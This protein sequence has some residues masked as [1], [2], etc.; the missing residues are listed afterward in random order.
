MTWPPSLLLHA[1]AHAWSLDAT[2]ANVTPEALAA[3]PWE[4]AFARIHGAEAGDHVNTTEDRPVGH[5]WLRDPSRAPSLALAQEIQAAQDEVV[6]LAEQLRTGAV[7]DVSGAA[8]TDVL[9]IGVGG[10]LLGPE[11]LVS[12]LGDDAHGRRR[13]LAVHAMDNIDPDGMR[14]VVSHLGDRLATTLVVLV[15]KS[16]T[17]AE[18]LA[19]HRLVQRV[20]A[21]RHLDHPGRY[22]AIT[23]P[24]SP[25][26]RRARRERWR[27]VLPLWPWVGGRFGTTSPAGL[28][29]AAL[30]GVDPIPLLAGAAAMDAWTRT[31]S[32]ASNP[33]A[34][35]AGTWHLLGHGRGDRSLVIM[36]YVDRL[37]RLGRWLQQLVME[38]IGKREDLHGARVE[39]GL[40][41]LGVKGSTDQHAYVQQLRDGRDDAL[42]L[43]VQSLQ[44]DRP[45]LHLDAQSTC[46]DVLQ[47]FLL[48]TRRALTERGRPS[49]TLT[50]DRLD[51]HAV[52]GLIA[53]FERAVELYA[54]LIDINAY[55]QPGVEAGK[56][57][58]RDVIAASIALREVLADADA[59]VVTLAARVGLDPLET[60]WVLRRL[61]A[62][63]VVHPLGDPH[64][65]PWRAGPAR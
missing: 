57:A 8:Y 58:A 9:H 42:V 51:E 15:S 18:P 24:D 2:V 10:S 41:V 11:L 54:G 60:L 40:T 6:S 44:H 49:L 25:L 30:A 1:P 21:E 45:E 22:V 31:A 12:A 33:A 39:Q 64:I 59:T 3:L 19:S 65:G 37:Q 16:G 48:G 32:P 47:G 27:A 43:F 28:F 4:Q 17:T 55:D 26:A 61:A 53:L 7:H 13:G 20:L 5:T 34:M 62:R 29:T 23:M 38:S 63:G 14:R 46:T 56:A 52:G 36:P 50:T 35:L